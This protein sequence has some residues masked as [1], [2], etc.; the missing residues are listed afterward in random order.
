M[1][2]QIPVEDMLTEL[3][4]PRPWELP[5]TTTCTPPEPLLPVGSASTKPHLLIFRQPAE[6]MLIPNP[7]TPL[8]PQPPTFIPPVLR[9]M[10]PEPLLLPSPTILTARPETV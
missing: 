9:S 2:L 4:W 5:I 7:P 8:S 10:A 3:T 1:Y 6:R